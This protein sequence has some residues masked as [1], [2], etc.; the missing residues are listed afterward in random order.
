MLSQ[1][2]LLVA[3]LTVAG[4]AASPACAQEKIGMLLVAGDLTSCA[5]PH[6]GLADQQSEKEKRVEEILSGRAT[7]Q[8]CD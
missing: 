1:G 6:K 4:M 7:R 5:D 3:A 8:A 2:R